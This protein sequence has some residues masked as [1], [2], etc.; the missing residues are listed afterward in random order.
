MGASPP[1]PCAK[2]ITEVSQQPSVTVYYPYLQTGK[3]RLREVMLLAQ[4]T[5]SQEMAEPGRR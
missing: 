5:H 2:Y 4:E 3:L 1:R